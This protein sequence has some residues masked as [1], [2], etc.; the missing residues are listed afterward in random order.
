MHNSIPTVYP[1]AKSLE[2]LCICVAQRG[3]D[4]TRSDSILCFSNE[5]SE[6]DKADVLK[7]VFST[8]IKENNQTCLSGGWVKFTTF[9]ATS[10]ALNL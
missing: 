9:G 5:T 6:Q 3:R 7:V 8:N 1:V 10:E 4:Q 2:T